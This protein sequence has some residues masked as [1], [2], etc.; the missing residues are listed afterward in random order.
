PRAWPALAGVE[1]RQQIE[2]AHFVVNVLVIIRA[3]APTLGWLMGTPRVRLRDDWTIYHDAELFITLRASVEAA[4]SADR[5]ESIAH[6]YRM[7]VTT[8]RS[9]SE[10][11]G[12]DFRATR[13]A[14][15][16]LGKRK[17]SLNATWRHLKS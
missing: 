12:T 9:L 6:L 17:G 13:T 10:L 3:V 2:T 14:L 1:G 16:Q 11:S 8:G 7:S 5:A 15:V 4:D